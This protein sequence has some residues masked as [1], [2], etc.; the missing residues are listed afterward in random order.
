MTIWFQPRA[1]PTTLNYP[2]NTLHT[3]GAQSDFGNYGQKAY[4]NEGPG[5]EDVAVLV[6]NLTSKK[7][8]LG[9]VPSTA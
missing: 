3:A 4:K 6:E 5:T 2:S 7:E 1:A 8:A 9:S